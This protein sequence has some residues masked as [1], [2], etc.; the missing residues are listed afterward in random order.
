M[1][2]ASADESQARMTATTTGTG[3][4]SSAPSRRS[5]TCGSACQP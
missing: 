4:I 1:N 5:G 3:A 2:E